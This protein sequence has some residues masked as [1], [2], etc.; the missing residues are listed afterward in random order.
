[1][2]QLQSSA[3]S[4]SALDQHHWSLSLWQHQASKLIPNM[5]GGGCLV[6]VLH[7]Y[8]IQY[9]SQYIPWETIIQISFKYISFQHFTTRWHHSSNKLLPCQWYL[10]NEMFQIMIE[11]FKFFNRLPQKQINAEFS[12]LFT[13]PNKDILDIATY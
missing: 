7:S 12:T 6:L 11:N 1:M 13:M 9:L 2:N 4:V 3:L 10:V 5:V 8:R